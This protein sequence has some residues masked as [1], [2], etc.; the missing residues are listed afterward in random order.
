MKFL[1][2]FIDDAQKEVPKHF[3]KRK[4]VEKNPWE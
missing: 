1:Q 4:R 2:I 3:L